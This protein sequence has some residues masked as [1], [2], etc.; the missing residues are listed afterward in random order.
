[1]FA[2]GSAAHGSNVKIYNKKFVS[3]T[4]AIYFLA[5][6]K[7]YHVTSCKPCGDSVNVCDGSTVVNRISDQKM[8]L[9]YTFK[10]DIFEC[11]NYLPSLWEGYNFLKH[12]KPINLTIDETAKQHVNILMTG[13]GRDFTGGEL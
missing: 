3:T 8:L 1:M 5:D 12:R 6:E 7:L 9:F 10:G 4:K 11:Q 2:G 13:V